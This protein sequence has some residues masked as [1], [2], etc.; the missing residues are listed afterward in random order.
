MYVLYLRYNFK[1]GGNEDGCSEAVGGG[2]PAPP[3]AAKEQR[4]EQQ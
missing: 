3:S 4:C 2:S 1:V